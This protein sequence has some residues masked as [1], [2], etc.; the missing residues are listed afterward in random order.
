MRQKLFHLLTFVFVIA[1]AIPMQ[2]KAQ[3]PDFCEYTRNFFSQPKSYSIESHG[4]AMLGPDGLTSYK[5][6][7]STF[8]VTA[9]GYSYRFKDGSGSTNKITTPLK[10]VTVL[11]S[12]G[13]VTMQMYVL[14]NGRA[15]RAVK[16]NDGHCAVH[17]YTLNNSSGKYVHIDW[18]TLR[19]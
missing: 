5:A 9:N 14:D 1:L 13:D 4:L 8:T 6:G 3:S 16:Y 17:T 2:I 18:F 19:K 11:S 10:N 15:V 12:R 7:E